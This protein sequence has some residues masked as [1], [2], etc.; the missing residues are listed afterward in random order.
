[1]VEGRSIVATK[2]HDIHRD[3]V[4]YVDIQIRSDILLGQ[5]LF[6]L[7]KD[8]LFKKAIG[9]GIDTWADYLKQPE[10]NISKSRAEKLIKAYQYFV[11]NLRFTVEELHGVPLYALSII[12]E[13]VAARK[14]VE[15]LI[16]D[17]RVLSE[18][19][20]KEKYHDDV[21]QT[22]RTY[23]YMVMKKCVETGSM[24]KL[25]DITSEEIKFAFRN[26]QL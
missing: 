2:A 26:K 14:K 24:E 9:A 11:L 10:I 13:K 22:T 15:E 12:A 23:R 5:S 4:G 21:T 3:V 7:K 19:D 1:M 16:N 25:H 20:F 18:K 6:L 17:A 8:N